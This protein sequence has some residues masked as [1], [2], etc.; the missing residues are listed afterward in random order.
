M[1][2]LFKKKKVNIDK[3]NEFCE[4]FILNNENI[5]ESV[6]NCDKNKQLMYQYLNLVESKLTELYIDFYKREVHFGYGPILNSDKFVLDLCHFNK[7]PLIEITKAVQ[8]KLN[9]ELSDKWIV[10][11]S[12]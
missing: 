10:N 9:K 7:K 1:F 4:W 8:E 11:I 5:R 6:L 2:N 12:K 3:V